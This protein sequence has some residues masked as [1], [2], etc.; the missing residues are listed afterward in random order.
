VFAVANHFFAYFSR[1]ALD[2]AWRLL[3]RLNFLG[4]GLADYLLFA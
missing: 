3:H 4:A 1:L 2:S